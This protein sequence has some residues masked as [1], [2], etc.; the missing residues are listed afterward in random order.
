MKTIVTFLVVS[1]LLIWVG[2]M[3]GSSHTSIKQYTRG[4]T[5]HVHHYHTEH[6]HHYDTVYADSLIY[7]GISLTVPI[8]SIRIHFIDPN[9][10]NR[11]SITIVNWR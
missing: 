2:W 9:C 6:I 1:L 10:D 8:T 4:D 11:D 3:C 5:V 7:R